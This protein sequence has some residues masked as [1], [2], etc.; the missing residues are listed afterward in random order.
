MKKVLLVLGMVVTLLASS[1]NE[2][3]YKVTETLPVENGKYEVV[4][5]SDTHSTIIEVSKEQYNK[6]NK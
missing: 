3:L 4:I 5:S 2:N 6:Y 1:C